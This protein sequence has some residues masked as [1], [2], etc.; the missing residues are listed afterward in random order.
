M[1][2]TKADLKR[3]LLSGLLMPLLAVP[4]LLLFFL[5]LPR[6]QMP[7]WH[8]FPPMPSRTT[9]YSET[10][11]PGSQSSIAESHSLAF[12]AEM[13]RLA[14]SQLYWRGT[15]FNRTDGNK[16]TRNSQPPSEQT[17]FKGKTVK[18][19]FYP[20]PT[21]SR[22]LIALDRPLNLEMQR[23][24]RSQ[25]YVFE[26][27]RTAGRRIS[28]SAVSQT[29]GL[30]AQ[31]NP[32]NRRYYLQLPEHLPDRVTSL[33]SQITSS[34]KDDRAKIELLENYFR[35]GNYRYLTRDLPTGDRALEQFLF[36]N[37]Q[38]HCEFFASS[39][40]LLLRAAAVPCRLVGGYLGGDYNDLGGYYLVTDAKAHVWVEAYIEGSGWLRMDPSSFAANA[41]DVWKPPGSP[42]LKLRITLLL[43]SFNYNWNRS[44]IS[45]DFEQQLNI[46][47]QIGSRIQGI[48]P[49]NLLRNSAPFVAV[50]LLFAGLF[51]AT[52]RTSL[53]LTREERIL[54]RFLQIVEG[55][56]NIS[57]DG[58][59]RAG[60]FEIAASATNGHVYDF[61]AIYSGAVY[62]D[63]KLTDAEYRHLQ[64]ILNI[65]KGVKSKNP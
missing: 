49:T 16:W 14:Q 43:D 47:N 19:I 5:I 50:V 32:I 33:A 46:A 63:R 59:G 41:G 24:S 17:L 21:Q 45:F 65:L 7:L 23:M 22:V 42:G 2:L 25:D 39:F 48:N 3:I 9:G 55:K 20:E 51:F 27:W 37:K 15:V 11:E 30:T 4:L 62:H 34:G 36:D 10:V 64:Q 31:S 8:I 60:L 12:R 18:Q 58:Q 52:R 61:V 38:G 40:A 44:V 6:T 57:A 35:N 13:P 56:F 26:L 54:R 1:M 53:F 29:N 28:Y